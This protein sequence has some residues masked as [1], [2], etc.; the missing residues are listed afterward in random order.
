MR[1]RC[2]DDA[3]TGRGGL[4]NHLRPQIPSGG[5]MWSLP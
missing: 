2:V 5:V 3:P 4:A 1:R